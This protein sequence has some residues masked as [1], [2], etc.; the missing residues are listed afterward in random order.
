MIE[1][2]YYQWYVNIIQN[3]ISQQRVKKINTYEKHH[4]IPD[5]LGGLNNKDNLVLLTFKEHFVC[6]HLLTK[7]TVNRDRSKMIF[8]F[9]SMSNK[10]GRKN[11]TYRITS[12]VYARLK[13]EVATLISK[14]NTGKSHP[15]TDETRKLISESKLGN[16]NP[17]HGKAAP[18]R[19]IMRPGV[20]GR[21]KGTAWSESERVSRLIQ[22]SQPGYY[23][24]LK[25]P[26]RG[27]KISEST[28]GRLGSA[29]GKQ[30]VNNGLVETYAYTCPPGYILGRLP[31]LQTNKQGMKWYNNGTVN[32]QFKDNLVEQ[33]FIRGRI[34]KKQ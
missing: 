33:G 27:K 2:K 7:F 25:N 12:N 5:S 14:N 29:D 15:V 20:G 4:I 19:G 24:Y 31:R 18:N 3:A 21:K 23:D 13:E 34:S 22:R 9:W 8:A 6:H 11:T 30:W 10:W 16:K 17:M 26:Q 32:R 28:K 1:N